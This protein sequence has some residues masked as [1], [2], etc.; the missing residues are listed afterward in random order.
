MFIEEKYIVSGSI[1]KLMILLVSLAVLLGKPLMVRA[2]ETSICHSHNSGCYGSNW[3]DCKDEVQVTTHNAD[4]NCTTCGRVASARVVV[5]KYSCKYMYLERE[6]RRIAYCY[7]CGNIV[8]NVTQSA[9]AVHRRQADV[10]VCGMNDTTIL[11][12]IVLESTSNGWTKDNVVLNVAVTEPTPGKSLAPYQFTFSGGSA[13]GSSCT[14]ESNGSY[15]VTVT[16]N[17]GQQATATVRVENI[18]KD[19]PQIQA[20]SVD[21]EY[22]EYEEANLVVEAVDALSGLGD[23][24]YSFDGGTNYG[25]SKTI[26]I[27]E[28]GNYTVFVKDNAGNI[29]SETLAVTCFAKKPE[30]NKNP[31]PQQTHTS[32]SVN[33]NPQKT[34]GTP[35]NTD[36]Y[37]GQKTGSN[38]GPNKPADTVDISQ[39]D[40]G[41]RNLTDTDSIEKDLERENLKKKLESSEHRVLLEDIPGMYSSV[42]KYNAEKNSVPTTLKVTSKQNESIYSGIVQTEENIVKNITLNG[43]NQNA[44]ISFA[45]VSRA[46]VGA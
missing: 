28:N 33:Q 10:L 39:K 11:A 30:V 17:N 25:N 20:F 22:P 29:S 18:D 3:I 46:V 38:T 26:R 4:F 12:K 5:E 44:D 27:T 41:K 36:V 42:L 14:V 31:V 7:S 6:F 45:Q 40:A 21:K 8:Q 37:N 2:A 19:A 23:N 1:K 15:S 24:A 9:S 35:G 13:V 34:P 43:E 16:G 32:S